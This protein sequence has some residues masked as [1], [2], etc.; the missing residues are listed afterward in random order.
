MTFKKLKHPLKN[1]KPKETLDPSLKKRMMNAQKSCEA[2]NFGFKD[3]D[4]FTKV[5]N[6]G[7]E[8]LWVR[9]EEGGTPIAFLVRPPMILTNIFSRSLL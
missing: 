2:R 4:I 6:G 3:T 5:E 8:P 1:W 7:G 9:E